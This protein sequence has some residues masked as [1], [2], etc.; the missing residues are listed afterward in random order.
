MKKRVRVSTVSNPLAFT[1]RPNGNMVLATL[2]NRLTE[3]DPTYS[4]II[5]SKV[6]QGGGIGTSEQITASGNNIIYRNF[7]FDASLQVSRTLNVNVYDPNFEHDT[8]GNYFVFQRNRLS[9]L[10]NVNL[11]T[12]T[13]NWFLQ[14][15]GSSM[16]QGITSNWLDKANRRLLATGG[17]AT[18]FMNE[19]L[20]R[21]NSPNLTAPAPVNQVLT[22]STRYP[23]YEPGSFYF[24]VDSNTRY[25]LTNFISDMSSSI[26]PIDSP[27]DITEQSVATALET[28]LEFDFELSS[29]NVVRDE[30][31]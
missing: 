25:P 2:D 5:A 17:S 20:L 9:Q 29:Y 7:V 18:V 4:T 27:V 21:P 8:G 31:S 14:T 24:V 13:L 28:N 6:Y 10:F 16:S 1:F 12:N 22:S 30:G 3:I 26:F 23:P 11:E 19:F 15:N